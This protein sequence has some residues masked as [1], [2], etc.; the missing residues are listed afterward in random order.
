MEL[1][2]LFFTLDCWVCCEASKL[3]ASFEIGAAGNERDADATSFVETL[4]ETPVGAFVEAT[5][6]FDGDDGACEDLESMA[7]ASLLFFERSASSSN[8]G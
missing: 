4:A 1:P 6:M 5:S 2:W 3:S 7:G 8:G